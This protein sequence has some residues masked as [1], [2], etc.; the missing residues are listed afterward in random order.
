[1]SGLTPLE[2]VRQWQRG[3]QSESIIPMGFQKT[4]R[5]AQSHTDL[6]EDSLALLVTSNVIDHL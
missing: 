1:M 2:S 3:V 6:L 5:S 4:A